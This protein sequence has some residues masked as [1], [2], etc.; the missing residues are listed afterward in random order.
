MKKIL[1]IFLTFLISQALSSQMGND[2]GVRFVFH[3]IVIDAS[4]LNPIP[5]S[6]IFVNKSFHSVAGKDGTFSLNI[7]RNDTIL[8]SILGYKP[9][10]FSVSDTLMGR[11]FNT[12]I[13]MQTDTLEIGEVI[14]LP[15]YAN[16]KSDILNAKPE[17]KAEFD[18]ARFNVAVSAYQGLHSQ[19]TI[20]D[21]ATN[22]MILRQ[23]HRIEAYEKGGI[24]SDRMVGISP[25]L[26]IPAAFLLIHGFPEPPSYMKPALTQQ[27]VD[28]LFRKYMETSRADK[29]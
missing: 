13:F 10:S 20:G 6:Q 14:I 2:A 22:Y 15:R 24:P 7:R 16:L 4:T 12:G 23:K 17:Q 29:K 11:E 9:V 5:G 19:V 3:G 26:L 8:F 28:Q 1:I 21:A 18:N 27:E 25:F